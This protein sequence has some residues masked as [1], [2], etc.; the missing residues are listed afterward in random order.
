MATV[1]VAEDIEDM[2]TLCRIALEKSGHSVTMARDGEE[3]VRIYRD[4]VG[5]L[6]NTPSSTSPFDLVILDQRMP[7][8]HGVEVANEILSMN[9]AQRIAFAAAYIGPYERAALNNP[10]V[11]ALIKPFEPKELVQLVEGR[12]KAKVTLS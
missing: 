6:Q 12:R 4:A 8:L 9:K 2:A 5:K 11:E 1:L 7:K 10:N 3:C